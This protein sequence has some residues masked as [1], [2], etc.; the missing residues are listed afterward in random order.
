MPKNS[1]QKNEFA[2]L[3][4]LRDE[5]KVRTH[6]LKADMKDEWR[7]LEGDWRKHRGQLTPAKRATEKSA[8]EVKTASKLLFKTVK[9]GYERIKQSLPT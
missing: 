7:K 2:S 4:Q 1:L 9:K 3:E 6:L 8:S 5:L